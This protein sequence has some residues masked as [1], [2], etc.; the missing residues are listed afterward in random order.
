MSETLEGQLERI[1]YSNNETLYTVAKLKVKGLRE[2]VTV[3]GKLTGITPGEVLRLS[4]AWEIHPKYGQ[5][6]KVSRWHVSFPSKVQGIEKY[7][8]SGL[9]PGIGPEMAKRLVA[10]FGDKTLEVMEHR[11]EAFLDVP[12]IGEKRLEMIRKAWEDQKEVRDVMI[13]LQGHGVSSGYSAKIF[14]QY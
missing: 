3:V 9:I 5:Q 1:V 8:G 7:L 4:G 2:L 12:G 6:F 14:K 11:L 10:R 13:F